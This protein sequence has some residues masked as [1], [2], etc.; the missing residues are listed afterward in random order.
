M[1]IDNAKRIDYWIN[2]K[3]SIFRLSRELIACYY[4][5]L[6][7]FSD[8]TEIND[9]AGKVLNEHIS[10]NQSFIDYY[11]KIENALFEENKTFIIDEGSN[12]INILD[13]PRFE[14]STNRTIGIIEEYNSEISVLCKNLDI[15][16]NQYIECLYSYFKSN[17]Q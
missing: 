16:I 8:D 3:E 12:T 1:R 5:L 9:I 6:I 10:V 7:Y 14:E 2:Y 11:P 15:A 17:I 13:L 4:R